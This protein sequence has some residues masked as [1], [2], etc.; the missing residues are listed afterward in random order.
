[1]RQPLL[2]IAIAWTLGILGADQIEA[3]ARLWLT[4]SLVGVAAT[5]ATSF[6]RDFPVW[7]AVLG[8]GGLW[9]A[10]RLD[11]EATG[12]TAPAAWQPPEW[13]GFQALLGDLQR[14][15]HE[16]EDKVVWYRGRG[17]VDYESPDPAWSEAPRW[18]EITLPVSQNQWIHPGLKIQGHGVRSAI[19]GPRVPGQRDFHRN[20]IRGGVHEQLRIPAVED[21]K[22]LSQEKLAQ[23]PRSPLDS[24]RRYGLKALSVGFRAEDPEKPLLQAMVLGAREDLDPELRETL[25]HAGTLHFFAI[26]GLHVG[27]LAGILLVAFQ[28]VGLTRSTTAITTLIALVFYVFLV[29]RPASACRATWM[30]GVMLSGWILHRPVQCMNS[31]ALAALTLLIWDPA[32]CFDPGFQLSFGVILSMS[33]ILSHP[34]IEAWRQQPGFPSEQCPAFLRKPAKGILMASLAS[35]G[36]FAGSWPLL[37]IHF[38]QFVVLSPFCSWLLMPL[39]LPAVAGGLGALAT[40]GWAPILAE[41]FNHVAW[42][43]LH[44]MLKASTWTAHHPW[45]WMAVQWAP[46]LWFW[47]WYAAVILL[48]FSQTRSDW[49][50]KMGI[51]TAI[52]SIGLLAWQIQVSR[53]ETRLDF[54][55]LDEG[56]SRWFQ[57]CSEKRSILWDCGTETS[58]KSQILP[59]LKAQGRRQLDHLILTHGDIKHL[60]GFQCIQQPMTP[61]QVLFSTLQGRS[62]SLRPVRSLAEEHPSIVLPATPG[63]SLLG[64]KLLHPK[65]PSDWTLADDRCQAWLGSMAGYNIL[66]LG[67]LSSAG[68]RTLWNQFPLDKVDI[69]QFGWS[70]ISDPPSAETLALLQP[71]LVVIT[72]SLFPASERQNRHWQRHY[73]E[74]GLSVW[75]LSETGTVTLKATPKGLELKTAAGS[76]LFWPGRRE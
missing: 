51:L 40:Y 5:F 54:L 24:C 47:I 39:A 1:M 29:G 20:A 26:S 6:Q 46:G 30:I 14:L 41:A 11:L 56:E 3:D 75:S 35:I 44:L 49:R 68:R 19:P 52:L 53:N 58:A 59:F 15:P 27:L 8:T 42:A 23:S 25:S 4:L 9:M 43:C 31:I 22:S 62:P 28:S 12:R 74:A 36:A 21:W 60:G 10:G 65:Q 73:R 2:P 66:M 13:V 55:A 50:M 64:W 16:A 69:I 70:S 7:L 72:D 38:H 67:D 61:A 33:T 34:A 17:Q 71:R 32:Q 45:G 37:A 76:R 57:S 63:A 48:A 18:V